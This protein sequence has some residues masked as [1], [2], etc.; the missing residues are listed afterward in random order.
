MRLQASIDESKILCCLRPHRLRSFAS[1]IFIS[2]QHSNRCHCHSFIETNVLHF[3]PQGTISLLRKRKETQGRLLKVV[4]IGMGP[5]RYMKRCGAGLAMGCSCGG[6]VA[7]RAAMMPLSL[8]NC[9]GPRSGRV[10]GRHGKMP[11]S[12]PVILL[13]QSSSSS[14]LKKLQPFHHWQFLD[15]NTSIWITVITMVTILHRRVLVSERSL[16]SH[17]PSQSPS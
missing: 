1:P 17:M 12:A 6:K 11:A 3:T 10:E 4:D 16:M 7:V 13:G 8:P 5:T 14:S 9:F 15:R 2:A